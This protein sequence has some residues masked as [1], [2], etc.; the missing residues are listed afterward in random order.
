MKNNILTIAFAALCAMPMT[1]QDNAVDNAVRA[2][3]ESNVEIKAER[4]RYESELRASESENALSGPEAEFEYK[5]GPAGTQNRWGVSV[6]QSFDWPGAYRARSRANGYRAEAFRY[7]TDA[8]RM[9]VALQARTLIYDYIKAQQGLRLLSEARTNVSKLAE[10]LDKAFEH[11]NVT[12]LEVMKARR[13]LL[14]IEKRLYEANIDSRKAAESI[15]ILAGGDLALED[16]ENFP[17]EMLRSHDE[18]RSRLADNNP[19]VA[20]AT[21]LVDAARADVSAAR[22]SA[23]PGF[24]VGF[25]HDFEEGMHFNGFSVGISLPFWGKNRKKAA[26]QAALSASVLDWN[27]AARSV[28]AELDTDYAEALHMQSLVK[29]YR[30]TFDSEKDYAALLEKAYYGGQLSMFDYLRELNDY[31]EYK[32]DFIDLEYRYSIAAARLNRYF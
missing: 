23:F 13:E 22:L 19:S 6:S 15:R 18:Y 24:S 30:S 9:D 2:I 3:L 21:V 20:A 26:A 31:I 25:K 32:L 14:A 10:F 28:I 1:A 4:A 17:E 8:K 27:Y 11:G 29:G 5:F 12:I 7:L 16:I